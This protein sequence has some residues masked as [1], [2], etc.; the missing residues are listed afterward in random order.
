MRLSN[1]IKVK[2]RICDFYSDVICQT[3]DDK[4]I[5]DINAIAKDSDLDE[6]NLLLQLVLSCVI[7][8]QRNEFIEKILTLDRDAQ[9]H[10]MECIRQL[11]LADPI[12]SDPIGSDLYNEDDIQKRLDDAL[13]KN[14]S[15]KEKNYELEIKN[16][17]LE[18]HM[19][20]LLQENEKLTQQMQK[21]KNKRR[22]SESSLGSNCFLHEDTIQ[23]LRQKNEDLQETIYKMEE[24]F[25]ESRIAIEEDKNKLIKTIDQLKRENELMKD[26]NESLKYL[27]A[28][29]EKLKQMIENQKKKFEIFNTNK[30]Q[31]K[32]EENT[33]LKDEI[34]TENQIKL[35]E[36]QIEEFQLKV[37]ELNNKIIDEA[38]KA[39]KFE[40][41]FNKI[42][43]KYNILI[44][45]K[46]SLL[47]EIKSLKGDP[48][49]SYEIIGNVI[50]NSITEISVT[51]SNVTEISVTE[52]SVTQS[53]VTQENTD[54][55]I[56]GNRN[57]FKKIFK[58][59]FAFLFFI[60]T[61]FM[62]FIF[63]VL[64]SSTNLPP[65]TS[66]EEII[67]RIFIP[68]ITKEKISKTQ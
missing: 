4:L 66:W 15:L 3:L 48:D 14:E 22:E 31:I 35:L 11:N 54:L 8:S 50:D 45:E 47:T 23:K 16:Q 10:L 46:E 33:N 27:Y 21:E 65:F 7:N 60:L 55:P 53:N 29:N 43:M 56:D 9:F 26:E 64:L 63:R 62:V 19:N 32:D 49:V 5:P 61:L 41:E 67:V 44:K 59:P 18:N 20:Y 38:S 36:S 37:N 42:N 39:D 68:Y 12:E 13:E 34:Q 40:F 57:I 6:L 51:Q 2:E 1:L 25:A 17:E 58:L 28:E 24:S 30:I 52:I